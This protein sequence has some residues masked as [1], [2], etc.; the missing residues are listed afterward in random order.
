V[1]TAEELDLVR[2]LGCDKVQGHVYGKA[3]P[4][5][6]VEALLAASR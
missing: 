5:A 4:R 6:D 3:M 1:E 2:V